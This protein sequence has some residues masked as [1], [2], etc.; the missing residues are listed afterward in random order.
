MTLSS[1]FDRL[2]ATEAAEYL[3]LKPKTLAQWRSDG[4]GPPFLKY[5]RVFYLKSDLEHFL[6]GR[7]VHSTAQARI[8]RDMSKKTAQD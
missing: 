8:K 7:K 1:P 4:S 6:E 2:N 3:G 5:G